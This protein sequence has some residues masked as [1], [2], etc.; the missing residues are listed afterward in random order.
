MDLHFSLAF[1]IKIRIVYIS[2]VLAC[3]DGGKGQVDGGDGR[4]EGQEEREEKGV[5]SYRGREVC[6]EVEIGLR[7]S[8]RERERDVLVPLIKVGIL[9]GCGAD[10]LNWFLGTYGMLG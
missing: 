3:V 1:L 6:G 7:Y 8:K 9:G 2:T 10:L 4:H 5:H